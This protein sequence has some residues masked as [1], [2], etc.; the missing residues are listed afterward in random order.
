MHAN[1]IFRLNFILFSILT[2]YILT[3]DPLD[4][5]SNNLKVA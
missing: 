1:L 3:D 5:R 4:F 2:Y